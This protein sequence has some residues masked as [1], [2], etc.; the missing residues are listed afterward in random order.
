M[1]ALVIGGNG[2]IGTALVDQLIGR[3][4]KVRVFDRYPSRYKE[5][6]DG[7]EY[8]I[9]D[10]AN[11]GEVSQAVQGVDWVFHLAYT[12]LPETSNEDP[13]YDVRS[14]VIDTIQLL[15][16]C[17]NAGVDKFVFVSSGGTIYGVPQCVPIKE[18][19]PTEP[20]CSYGITK[21]TIEKYLHLFHH[22]KKL[23]YSVARIANPYGERQNPNSKQGAV[24]VFLGC[25]A[26]KQPI[27]VFGD[28]EIVRDFIYIYDAA[29]A[30]IACADYVASEKG[31]R[32]F[33]IGSGVGYSLNQIVD[34]IRNVVDV[35]VKVNHTP[36][37]QVDVKSNVLDIELARKLL[38]WEP[39]VDLETGIKRAWDWTKSLSLV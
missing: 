28:G 9:G 20:I 23:E 30:L 26:R 12:T 31:P 13:V 22:T 27:T 1:K 8:L 4:I 14:N 34:T 37:R 24:G 15:Q 16:E 2:F 33:N 35:E 17:C 7:V 19:H 32:V 11:H 29:D 25:I 10:F 6:V 36:A 3:G 39:K 18:E 5:P 21:L 38:K